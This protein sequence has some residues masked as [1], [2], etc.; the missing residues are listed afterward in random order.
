[1]M[2]TT[3]L[4]TGPALL[5]NSFYSNQKAV[6]KAISAW[7]STCQNQFIIDQILNG[8]KLEFSSTPA[9]FDVKGIST[10]G[11]EMKETIEEFLAKGTIKETS[12]NQYN[13]PFF[14]LN[15]KG[16]QRPILDL[17]FL[18][19]HLR[20]KKF[21][22]ETLQSATSI[23]RKN[24]Y[25]TKTDIK[26]AYLA[27]PI[28]QQHQQYLGFKWMGREFQFTSLPFG[29]S[30]APRTFTKIMR[31]ALK[32][33]RSAG[34]Q[35]IIYL[36]DVLVIGDTLEECAEQT[37]TMRSHLEALGFTL[38][39]DKSTKTPT[40]S[41]EFLGMSLNSKM[42]T[43]RAPQEKITSI[44]KDLKQ[45]ISK[46]RM[47]LRKIAA[48]AGAL[49]ALSP[50]I[51]KALIHQRFIQRNIAKHGKICNWESLVE[52]DK[53]TKREAEELLKKLD[54]LNG[55]SFQV[56]EKQEIHMWTDASK[57]GWGACS[58]GMHHS[59]QWR[60]T[61]SS[62]SSNW[63]ELKAIW[64]MLKRA[65]PNWKGKKLM[66]HTDNTTAIS[67][68][69][70]QSSPRHP[71]LLRLAKSIWRLAQLQDWTLSAVHIAGKKNVTA[72]LLSRLKT[73]AYEWKLDNTNWRRIINK[74]GEREIDLFAAPWNT[75]CPKFYSWHPFQEAAGVDALQQQW[76]SRAYANPPP[77]LIPRVIQK[78]RQ[79][80]TNLILVTPNWEAQLW[81]PVLKRICKKP[82]KLKLKKESFSLL[83][84][85]IELPFREILAWN[86]LKRTSSKQ[87]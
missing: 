30:S 63:R 83:G 17:R 80:R 31:E 69:N 66:I 74:W 11:L 20:S 54:K 71:H 19:N 49:T 50:A 85:R 22:M 7:K 1:M 3:P 41:I 76:P 6:T 68:I 15:Q 34:L 26:S 35:C 40:Q 57:W 64:E 52:I 61:E 25:F 28:A 16:K 12:N 58:E 86:L 47:S 29:L 37:A 8:V 21:Q 84:K 10:P 5:R 24:Q 67:Q 23:I 4:Q 56:K 48:I 60:T 32:S 42:L 39:Q 44:K 18:N 77:I 13:S 65:P 53:A 51:D 62:N 87:A 79:E 55:K 2:E 43:I 27:I 78:W 59:N 33:L 38:N 70:R 46:E 73:N 9:P 75:Q 36:D 72:D 14:M 45:L 82:M 81:F